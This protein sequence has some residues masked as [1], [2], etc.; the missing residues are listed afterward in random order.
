MVPQRAPMKHQLN[1]RVNGFSGIVVI[2]FGR[3]VPYVDAK[4]RQRFDD[5]QREGRDWR[6]NYTKRHIRRRR[7]GR[8]VDK[9]RGE[10]LHEAPGTDSAAHGRHRRR[11][12]RLAAKAHGMERCS[13]PLP[14]RLIARPGCGRKGRRPARARARGP[15]P[16]PRRMESRKPG[17]P[18]RWQAPRPLPFA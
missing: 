9:R 17:R 8:V 1:Q 11:V 5:R 14:G 15:A 18:G 16:S 3:R 10:L 7:G 4:A 13:P 2:D 6:G 12:T